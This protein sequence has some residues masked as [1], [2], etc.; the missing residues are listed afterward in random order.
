MT[1]QVG[2]MPGFFI[3]PI[4]RFGSEWLKVMTFLPVR[5]CIVH[6]HAA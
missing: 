4:G 1:S 6:V 5:T 3:N 2:Q